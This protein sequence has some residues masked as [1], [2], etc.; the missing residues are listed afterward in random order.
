M[1]RIAPFRG[2]RFRE[3]VCG[4]TGSLL[5][6]AYDAVDDRLT[7]K[8]LSAS[9]HN[10]LRLEL[11]AVTPAPDQD[12]YEAAADLFAALELPQPES[13]MSRVPSARRTDRASTGRNRALLAPLKWPILGNY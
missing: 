13:A 8:L 11:P 10:V 9:A 6:T 4:P 7:H 3:E 2:L 1:P 5:A 12:R